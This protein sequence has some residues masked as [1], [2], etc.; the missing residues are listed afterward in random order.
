MNEIM[1][2]YRNKKKAKKEKGY[3][4]GSKSPFLSSSEKALCILLCFHLLFKIK[5]IVAV[6]SYRN[7]KK[8]NTS[9]VKKQF[10]RDEREKS[11]RERERDW[12]RHVH[13]DSLHAHQQHL[14]SITT[15]MWAG[16]IIPAGACYQK[17][18]SS[19]K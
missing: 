8:K 4:K 12:Y 6:Q 5:Q 18:V 14:A 16:A 11:E 2:G 17:K 15:K 7:P 1:V 19:I 3:F 10:H 9:K 13:E